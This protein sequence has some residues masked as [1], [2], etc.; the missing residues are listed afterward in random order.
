MHLIFFDNESH[1]FPFSYENMFSAISDFFKTEFPLNEH[2][3]EELFS[4]FR[5]THYPANSMLLQAETK[6]KK[7]RFLNNG[8]V[9]EY[10]YNQDI[11]RNINFYV[12]P[13][14][15]SD[16]LAFNQNTSTR[17]YQECLSAVEV[18]SIDRHIFFE[19]LEK[20]ECGKSLVT[21]SFQKLL[22]QKESFEYNHL[23]K[24]PETRYLE[25]LVKKP[26]WIRYIPQYHIAS[27]LNITPETLSRIRK[28][29]S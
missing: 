25:L 14:F 28:R 22:T 8:I 29:I 1:L 17:K 16:L 23:T 24:N 11:E 27:Y 20:Y 5:L 12:K 18:L 10:Y 7:L 26:E 4:H 6:E 9:R 2:G 13:Q 15:I 19:L 21:S 3:L